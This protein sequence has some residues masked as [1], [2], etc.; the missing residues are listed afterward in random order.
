MIV[1]KL[2]IYKKHNLR[3]DLIFFKQ[4]LYFE[5]TFDKFCKNIPYIIAIQFSKQILSMRT[6]FS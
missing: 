5:N 4:T 1:Y 6:S 3:S 2:N